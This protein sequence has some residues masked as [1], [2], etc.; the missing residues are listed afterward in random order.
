MIKYNLKSDLH[1]FLRKQIV[2]VL[3]LIRLS[4]LM[5]M[6]IFYLAGYHFITP[7]RSVDLQKHFK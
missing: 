4:R 2:I 7:L 5:T 1:H 3:I 6:I